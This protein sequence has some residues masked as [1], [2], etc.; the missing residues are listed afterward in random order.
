M[1]KETKIVM[2]TPNKQSIITLRAAPLPHDVVSVLENN[3]DLIR[4]INKCYYNKFNL[5]EFSNLSIKDDQGN[6]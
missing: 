3:T 2:T 4:L 6:F 5:D 1:A